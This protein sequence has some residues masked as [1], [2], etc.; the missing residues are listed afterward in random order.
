MKRMTL[1]ALALCLIM[2]TTVGAGVVAAKQ[3]ENPSQAGVSSIY[4]YDVKA[5]DTHGSGKLMINLAEQK[6][7]FNGKGFDPGNTYYLQYRIGNLPGIHTFASFTTTPSGNLHVTGTWVKD[8]ETPLSALAFTVGAT[9]TLNPVLRFAYN[10]NPDAWIYQDGIWLEPFEFMAIGSTGPIVTY[11]L[12]SWNGIT[13]YEGPN[14]NLNS[15]PT[16]F[17]GDVYVP[18]D[19]ANAYF[20]LTVYDSAGNSNSVTRDVFHDVG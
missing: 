1:I 9:N 15:D 10:S 6:F 2:L 7:A 14:A 8:S 18:R 20:T 5:T 16:K 19:L 11:K 17:S 13:V 4:F 3:T 12:V